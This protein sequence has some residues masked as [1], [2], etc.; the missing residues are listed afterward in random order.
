MLPTRKHFQVILSFFLVVFSLIGLTWINYRFSA[1]NPGGNDFM[2]YWNGARSWLLKGLSPYDDRVGLATQELIRGRPADS[3]TGEDQNLFIYP[4]FSMVFFTPFGPINYVLA[5]ALWMTILELA[6]LVLALVS[7]KLSG[8]KLST[9]GLAAL[10][11]FSLLWYPGFRTLIL[12]QYS[13]IN[14]LLIVAAILMVQQKHD[15]LAGIFLAFS[16][17]KPQMSYLIIPFILLWGVSTKRWRLV[18]SILGS[19]ILI[20]ILPMLLIPD[21]P[22]QWIRQVIKYPGYTVPIGTVVEII[23][24]LIPGLSLP[25]SGILYAFFG[26]FLLREWFLAWGKDERWFIWTAL[27][28]LIITNIITFRNVTTHYVELLPVPLLLFQIWKESWGSKGE[29]AAW[30]TL[31][32]LLFGMWA[33]FLSTVQGTAEQAVMYPAFPLACFAGLWWVR[34]H[35]IRQPVI[36]LN[37]IP[38]ITL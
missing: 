36:L 3:A 37:K 6:A 23:S 24:G 8:W 18:Q 22:L 20:W 29:I 33:L 38:Q 15:V 35:I 34:S 17:S 11:L 13:G 5:R 12:G 30:T 14:A 2:T 4:L 32:V 9:T 19:S 26:L 25:L 7:L 31:G 21:W 28:T 1:Q 27:M 10:F 16:M